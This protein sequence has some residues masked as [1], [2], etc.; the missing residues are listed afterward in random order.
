MRVVIVDDEPW[1]RSV[2][3]SLGKWDEYN[4]DIVAE[5]ENGQQALRLIEE[6]QAEIVITDMRMPGLD[7]AE[8]LQKLADT[9]PR[10]KIIVVSGYQ[11]FEYL[12]EA[13]R[14]QAV[15]YLLK[16]VKGEELNRC[17][18]EVIKA[19]RDEQVVDS[20]SLALFVGSS[21][22]EQYLGYRQ[23]IYQHLLENNRPAVIKG[24]EKLEAF[25]QNALVSPVT[26]SALVT[27]YRDYSLLL[28]ELGA[29]G[30]SNEDRREH[31]GLRLQDCSTVAQ[32]IK[33]LAV[34][35]TE[36]I[37]ATEKQRLQ[38]E[39]LDMDSVVRHLERHFTDP[40][41]LET[42]AQRFYV[43]KEHLSRRFKAFTGETMSAYIARKRME[44]AK[45][46]L[47]STTLPLKDIAEMVGY[48]ELAYFHRVF[49]KYY[50]TTPKSL[51]S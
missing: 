26:K 36:H 18:E 15:E 1:A 39:Q 32:L 28:H 2:I 13:I 30:S 46:L 31:L 23:S 51:R 38:A 9:F 14:S 35:Y 37:D 22:Q 42:V 8:L 49:K 5:A 44:K 6:Y 7:G 29:A 11:D 27:V 25:L 34:L 21:D 17:L 40:I 43:T 50:G 24:L 20:H 12:R 47:T 41:S 33:E 45:E 16:P 10:L 3:R 48:P 19:Y 4:L